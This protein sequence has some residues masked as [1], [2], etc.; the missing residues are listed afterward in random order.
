M[1]NPKTA[2]HYWDYTRDNST[3]WWDSPI[4]QDDW[5]GSNSPNNNFHAIDTGRWAYT[6]VPS[7]TDQTGYQNPYGLLRSPWN[8]NPVPYVMRYNRTLGVLGDANSNFPSCSSFAQYIGDSLATIV[9]AVDGA[10]HG[11]VHLMIGGTWDFKPVWK[12][13]GKYLSHPDALL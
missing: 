4:F 7:N 6:R 11:P 3:S 1:I 8:T 2:A 10:L 5:F 13:V 12:D 9:E